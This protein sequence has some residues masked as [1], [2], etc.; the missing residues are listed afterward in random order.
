M[1]AGICL[2]TAN[3]GNIQHKCFVITFGSYN[4]FRNKGDGRN[5]MSKL[6]EY[7]FELFWE[8]PI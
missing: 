1:G 6:G 8:F 3:C 7:N 5:H 2:V 4:T